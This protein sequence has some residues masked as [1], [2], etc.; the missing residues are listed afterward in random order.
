MQ[1]S[2]HEYKYASADELITELMVR[3]SIVDAAQGL[4]YSGFEFKVFRKSFANP[5]FWN[6]NMI[7]GF[8]LK[9]DVLPSDAIDDILK[10]GSL[11]GTEC[12]TAMIIVY[13]KAILDVLPAKEFNKLYSSIYLMNWDH[14][15]RDLAIE[16]FDEIADELPGDARYFIN[17]DVDP[18]QPEWQGENV[19]Y[20]GD[21]KYYGHGAG[22]KDAKGIIKMLNGVRK[23][24]AQKSAYLLEGAKRQDYRLLTQYRMA[25]A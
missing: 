9:N 25:E 23:A 12:S 16:E 6:R 13:Y 5:A 3:K 7:G 2:A 10:N 20:L 8:N 24:G 17:P 18:L 14:L 4:A 22:I 11:Y 15:D 21:G 1:K 19:F